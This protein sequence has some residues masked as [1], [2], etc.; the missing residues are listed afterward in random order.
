MTR[1]HFPTEAAGPSLDDTIR[2]PKGFVLSLIG[3]EVLTKRNEDGP[4]ARPWRTASR[5][6]SVMPERKEGKEE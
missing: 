4:L 2:D 5:Q 1:K 3:A 6:H